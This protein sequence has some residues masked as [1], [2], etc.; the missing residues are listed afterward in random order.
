MVAELLASIVSLFCLIS[1]TKLK[2]KYMKIE[3]RYT[4]DQQ[5]TQRLCTIKWR[6]QL[7]LITRAGF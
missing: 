7:F 1:Y 6:P 2:K 3:I 5:M 4:G